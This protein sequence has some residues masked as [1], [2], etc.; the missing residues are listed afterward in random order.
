MRLRYTVEARDQIAAIYSYIND[1]N[2]EAARQVIARIRSAAK[3]LTEFPAHRPY[4]PGS[5]PP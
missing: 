3:R 2:P 5:R 4:W 1:R